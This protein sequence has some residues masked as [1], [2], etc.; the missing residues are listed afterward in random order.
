MTAQG[1]DRRILRAFYT[2]YVA[3][4]LIILVFFVAAFQAASGSKAAPERDE[5]LAKPSFFGDIALS[6]T[7]VTDGLTPADERR[8]LA[9]GEV[10]RTHDVNATVELRVPRMA[11]SEINNGA[12]RAASLTERIDHLLQTQGAPSSSVRYIIRERSNSRDLGAVVR[13]QW[14]EEARG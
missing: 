5:V 7:A 11:L 14:M 12:I 10:L 4:L 8:L 1:A 9:I 13:I 2:Q 3:V 6:D